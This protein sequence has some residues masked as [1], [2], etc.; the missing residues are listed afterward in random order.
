M[1]AMVTSHPMSN[2]ESGSFRLPGLLCALVL[3]II[4]MHGL[5]AHGSAGH[6]PDTAHSTVMTADHESAHEEDISAHTAL[7][8]VMPSSANPAGAMTLCAAMLTCVGVGLLLLLEVRR[9]A[10]SGFVRIRVVSRALAEVVVSIYRPSAVWRYS[11][12]RC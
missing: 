12:I 8:F 6:A 9:R 10:P 3:G 11:V 5:A 1:G 2:W 4:G 7:A